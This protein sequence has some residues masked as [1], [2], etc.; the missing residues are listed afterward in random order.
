MR[1]VGMKSGRI[2]FGLIFFLVVA[3][4]ALA[5]EVG[6]IMSIVGT[7]EVLRKEQWQS[8]SLHE[9]LQP[10]DVVRTGPGSRVAVLL[11]D[12]SQLKVNANSRLLL[13]QVHAPHKARSDAADT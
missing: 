7:A 9:A 8:V 10:G 1:R 5:Q 12:G 6:K 13:K 3:Y 11:A 4:P 2:F